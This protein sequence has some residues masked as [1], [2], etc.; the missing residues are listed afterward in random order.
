[1]SY[2]AIC[3]A[4]SIAQED[5]LD[6][7][8][9]DVGELERERK[10]GIVLSGFDGVHCLPRNCQARCKIGLGPRALCAQDAE[11]I[12]HRYRRM[13]LANPKIQEVVMIST[14]KTLSISGAPAALA[15]TWPIASR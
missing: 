10:R 1:M 2:T 15:A 3:S 7:H 11:P 12:L 13:A 14:Q 4:H 6:P 9:E 8:L 5:V